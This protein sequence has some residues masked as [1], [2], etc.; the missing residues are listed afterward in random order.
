MHKFNAFTGPFG[1]VFVK[2]I[3]PERDFILAMNMPKRNLITVFLLSGL[4]VG[5]LDIAAALI[6]Y[7]AQ[8]GKD[9]LNV[10]RFIASGVFGAAAFSGGVPMAGWGLF[11]H[12]IIA[13]SFTAFFFFI[14]SKWAVL[15]KNRWLTGLCYGIFIWFVMNVLV[16]PVSN[17][18]QSAFNLQKAV[19]AAA[20]L[21]A[22][23]GLPLSF[24]AKRYF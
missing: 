9:P 13:F 17:V 3:A 2:I 22:A 21:V 7:Y 1:V 8:T 23:I 5:T 4:L 18:P 12:F 6:Q 16:L 19:V 11:F 14:Y 20:I 15:A 24:I 10:P